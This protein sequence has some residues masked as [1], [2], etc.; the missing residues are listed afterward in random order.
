MATAKKVLKWKLTLTVT[1]GPK[2][3]SKD[4]PDPDGLSDLVL[5]DLP[6]EVWY[7]NTRLECTWEV[8]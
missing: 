2:I 4:G 3:G 6:S 5:E 1:E 7:D 8:A